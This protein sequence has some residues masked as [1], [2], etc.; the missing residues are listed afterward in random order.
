MFSRK[1]I[2]KI[3]IVSIPGKRR[4]KNR[5][6]YVSAH[7][8]QAF[9]SVRDSLSGKYPVEQINL[10]KLA[11][12]ERLFKRGIQILVLP[13][14]G[15]ITHQQLNNL[16]AFVK[17]GGIV[18][19][20]YPSLAFDALD[21][22][23]NDA[24]RDGGR[25]KILERLRHLFGVEE[26][27]E[28]QVSLAVDTQNGGYPNLFK[29]APKF[30]NFKGKAI[31]VM[32]SN[33]HTHGILKIENIESSDNNLDINRIK[34]RNIPCLLFKDYNYNGYFIYATIPVCRN[35]PNSGLGAIFDELVHIQE[36]KIR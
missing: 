24:T 27:S 7:Y 6:K 15:V 31:L 35:L 17:L 21:T 10:K 13:E 25:S 9:F 22:V 28:T 20:D 29:G 32:R 12:F 30:V 33:C 23:D 11:K 36:E 5:L 4:E 8:E 3:G 14:A 16:E 2:V 26:A 18:F 1:R 19:A 34:Q